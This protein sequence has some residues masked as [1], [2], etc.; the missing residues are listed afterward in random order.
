MPDI[1]LH[2]HADPLGEIDW[3]GMSNIATPMRIQDGDDTSEVHATVQLFV[4]LADKHA[5]G[6]HMSRL[7]R[8]LGSYQ[9][10][11]ALRPSMLIELLEAMVTSHPESAT[12][13]HVEMKFA[14]LLTREALVSD[15]SGWHSYP[16]AIRGEVR[17]KRVAIELASTIYYSSTCPASAALSRQAIQE[18]FKDK[19]DNNSEVSQEAIY[20]WLGTQQAIVATPHGQRSA[21]SVKVRLVE[22][23]QSFP[24]TTLINEVE[25]AVGTPVQTAV[26]RE[27]EREFA[28]RNAQ[29]PMFCEDAVRYVANRL[30]SLDWISDFHVRV[31]HYESLHA[32]NAVGISTKGIPG[33]YRPIA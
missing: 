14:H 6:I 2:N 17:D 13:A 27:D 16:S 5:K 26:K 9:N 1:A 11:N 21:A 19:F 31:E 7:Y 3:V 8:S 28:I 12:S 24:L 30:D 32:H 15:N 22:A 25:N 10:G 33:G 4:D 29:N 20:E 23:I 18:K